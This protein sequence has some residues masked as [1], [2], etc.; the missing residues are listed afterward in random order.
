MQILKPTGICE[1]YF[2]VSFQAK[3][4]NSRNKMTLAMKELKFT[5]KHVKG[6]SGILHFRCEIAQQV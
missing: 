1:G 3:I 2:Y 4:R 6:E 5:I